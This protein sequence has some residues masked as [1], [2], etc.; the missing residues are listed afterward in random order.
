M[1]LKIR[2]LHWSLSVIGLWISFTGTG[3][4]Q[5]PR[6]ANIFNY[7]TDARHVAL[8]GDGE[9]S[10]EGPSLIFPL[11]DMLSNDAV[12]SSFEFRPPNWNTNDV[13]PFHTFSVQKDFDS[14]V[15]AGV[16]IARN[17]SGRLNPVSLNTNTFYGNVEPYQ[18]YIVG[19]FNTP[20][21]E[22]I[23][24]G[25]S[26]KIYSG[27]NSPF[28]FFGIS[29][30][31]SG[32]V[33]GTAYLM[34]VAL[35][36]K[37]T[38][39][40]AEREVSE[41][42]L[43][44]GV[45]NLGSDIVYNDSMSFRLPRSFHVDAALTKRTE[46]MSLL[47]KVHTRIILNPGTT[48]EHF[49]LSGGI[50]AGYKDKVFARL[51]IIMRPF[52]SIFGKKFTPQFAAGAGLKLGNEENVRASTFIFSMDVAIVPFMGDSFPALLERSDSPNVVITATVTYP[53]AWTKTR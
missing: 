44:S 41:L 35:Q 9:G 37:V 32:R 23:S 42:L 39:S 21:T 36:K 17:V 30:G 48:D 13:F 18:L 28:F 19:F 38:F 49:Y 34:D 52:D 33:Q 43:R 46:S 24:V 15:M 29:S 12:M 50:E 3:T 47:Y 11:R 53:I 51:G 8:G 26:G 16:S 45:S 40:S 6:Y 22:D 5:Y 25:M 27:N 20:L 10:L 31:A 2:F 14:V 1:R 4:A 7:S